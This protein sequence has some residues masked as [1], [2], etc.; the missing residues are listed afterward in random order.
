MQLPIPA[1]PLDPLLSPLPGSP[2]S[3]L[4]GS[5][6][7]PLPGSPLSPLPGSPLN[8]SLVP[9]TAPGG[10]LD[11]LSRALAEAADDLAGRRSA[12]RLR[13]AAL[14]WHSPAARAFAAALHDLLGQLGQSSSRLAELS[15]A[16][17]SHRQR[18]ADRAGAVTRLAHAGGDRILAAVERMVGLP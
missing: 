11:A 7:S 13:A 9:S 17:R 6:L 8:R 12:L 15:T 10:Q 2:L 18:A 16:V 14:R 1:T 3:P 5:P 4:P